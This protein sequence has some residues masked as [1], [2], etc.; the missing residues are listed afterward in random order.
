MLETY[1][2]AEV[3]LI[4]GLQ[5]FLPS[6]VAQVL[7]HFSNVVAPHATFWLFFP[8]L[9]F[10]HVSNGE[11]TRVTCSKLVFAIMISDYLNMMMKWMFFGN[12]PYW[13]DTSLQQFSGTCETGPGNPSG[14]CMVAA[15]AITVL[16]LCNSFIYK[17]ACRQ[18]CWAT[19]FLVAVSRLY[20]AAHFP[21][22]VVWGSLFGYYVGK[23]A[24]KFDSN[25]LTDKKFWFFIGAFIFISAMA[26]HATFVH[27]LGVD[28]DWTIAKA[29]E[30]CSNPDWVHKATSPVNTIF[31]VTGACLGMAFYKVERTSQVLDSKQQF[32]KLLLCVGIFYGTG[33]GHRYYSDPEKVVAFYLVSCLH[34][35]S[36]PV[37]LG[38]LN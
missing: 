37:V 38:F 25:R 13:Y 2:N 20:L 31:K 7:Q 4:R 30:A 16:V 32:L 9:H 26:L 24:L 8:I 3:A 19:I 21:H 29:V 12:R 33:Y 27:L 18:A 34:Y 10:F 15:S 22:Q 5:T 35:F 28:L 1:L 6:Q 36:I 11:S 14:H 23:F 17:K